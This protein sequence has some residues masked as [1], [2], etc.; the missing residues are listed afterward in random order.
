MT[1]LKRLIPCHNLSKLVLIWARFNNSWQGSWNRRIENKNSRLSNCLTNRF[2]LSIR[3]KS[4]FRAKLMLLRPRCIRSKVEGCIPLSPGHRAWAKLEYI[5]YKLRK[6]FIIG[7]ATKLQ[8]MISTLAWSFSTK[9]T[10]FNSNSFIPKTTRTPWIASIRFS[11]RTN[12]T[13]L[14]T[15]N[16]KAYI[17]FIQWKP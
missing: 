6:R 14:R 17:N 13:Y 9:S 2:K 16:Q 8:I 5:Y 11:H 15:Q 4:L 12:Q 10:L 3:C 7:W 1:L